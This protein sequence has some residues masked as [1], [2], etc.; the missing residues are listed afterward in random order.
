[1]PTPVSTDCLLAFASELA[2]RIEPNPDHPRAAPHIPRSAPHY[3]DV[4]VGEPTCFLRGEDK[5]DAAFVAEMPDD[6]VVVSFRG[7]LPPFGAPFWSWV[8]DWLED[9]DI[10]PVPWTVA[11]QPYGRVEHGFDRAVLELWNDIQGVGPLTTDDSAFAEGE[12]ELTLGDERR[13]LRGGIR[14]A[15]LHG[16]ID[17]ST[18]TGILVTGH[19]KGA[20]ATYLA[21]SLIRGEPDLADVPVRVACFAS[22]YTCDAAFLQAYTEAGLEDATVRYQNV[23]DLVPFVPNYLISLPLRL[24]R[25]LDPT[26][27]ASTKATWTWRYVTIGHLRVIT[28]A[29][30]IREGTGA[31]WRALLRIVVDLLTLQVGRIADAHSL[32][33]DPDASHPT[34]RYMTAVCRASAPE[35]VRLGAEAGVVSR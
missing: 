4:I 18:K 13:T 27:T 32:V 6:T 1:M 21:A 20:A 22:P 3:D 19:S 26:S 23:D 2:Y 28:R 14:H 31:Y 34:G 11:G 9:F 25:W 16:G 24:A 17:W 15:L 12:E 10:D 8:E 30:D 29:C 7:T 5:I 33:H 35:P